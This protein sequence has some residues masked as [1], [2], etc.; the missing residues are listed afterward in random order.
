MATRQFYG[1]SMTLTANYNKILDGFRMPK[2][3]VYGKDFRGLFICYDYKV[4]KWVTWHTKERGDF[5]MP[6]L[7]MWRKVGNKWHCGTEVNYTTA[8]IIDWWESGDYP[9]ISWGEEKFQVSTK[10]IK[11]HS[12]NQH[13]F[14]YYEFPLPRGAI[15]GSDEKGVFLCKNIQPRGFYNGLPRIELWRPIVGGVERNNTTKWAKVFEAN[16]TS[17][18]VWELIKAKNLE[19]DY[20]SEPHDIAS[21]QE[22]R[23]AYDTVH[24][25][26]L[27]FA[28]R[29]G[30]KGDSFEVLENPRTLDELADLQ[31]GHAV[32]TGYIPG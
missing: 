5:S 1:G 21:K 31:R 9:T 26:G 22:L 23:P 3:A 2:G 32:R 13:H 11:V 12:V 7:K 28:Y 14:R 10:R 8:A 30:P 27:G 15:Y 29:K 20:S 25:T 16:A 17:Y 18:A 24:Y 4:R 19:L 6:V